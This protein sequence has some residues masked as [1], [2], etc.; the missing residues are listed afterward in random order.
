[1]CWILAVHLGVYI[2]STGKIFMELQDCSWSVVEQPHVVACGRDEFS[3]DTLRFYE[4]IKKCF[5]DQ[6]VNVILFSSVLQYVENP[7]ELLRM[8][9]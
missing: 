3:T 8:D 6:P 1:M 4:T 5:S 9:V 7:Y 2:C